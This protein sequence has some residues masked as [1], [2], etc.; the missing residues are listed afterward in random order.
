M[1]EQTPTKYFPNLSGKQLDKLLVLS[2]EIT[3]WNSKI[4][5][6]SRKDIDNIYIHHILHS[7]AVA[8]FIQFKPEANI[9]DL[10]TGGGFPGIPLS[11]LFPQTNFV[12][13]DSRKKKLFVVDEICKKANIQNVQTVH[14]RVEEH[15]GKYDFVVTRAVARTSN[16]VKWTSKLIK[17]ESVHALPNGLIALKGGELKEELREASKMTYCEKTPINTYFNEEFFETKF[18]VYAQS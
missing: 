10:G 9:L 16:L 13:L 2:E 12:L 8:K 7:L 5:V 11:I 4:N 6:V 17:E 18:I 3:N 14:S 1:V 15:K